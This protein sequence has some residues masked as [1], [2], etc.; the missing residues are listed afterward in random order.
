MRS[1]LKIV[2]CVFTCRRMWITAIGQSVESRSAFAQSES[3]FR[4]KGARL[5]FKTPKGTTKE[6]SHKN[7]KYYK[8]VN[9]Q[10]VV[11][12]FFHKGNITVN[13]F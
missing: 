6:K 3:R 1:F 5:G 12:Y 2:A 9:A 10:K 8:N 4:Y 11:L 13:M 7:D